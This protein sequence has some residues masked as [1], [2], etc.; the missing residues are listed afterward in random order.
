M[1]GVG[2]ALRLWRAEIGPLSRLAAAVAV[3][4]AGVV[5]TLDLV[6]WSAPAPGAE[7]RIRELADEPRAVDG[8]LWSA[9]AVTRWALGAL[10]YA[11]VILL[12][13]RILG[14]SRRPAPTLGR[15]VAALAG[16]L[17]ATAAFRIGLSLPAAALLAATL[18]AGTSYLVAINLVHAAG[19]VVTAP[20]LAATAWV[21]LP[22][23]RPPL[24]GG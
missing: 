17:A 16:A 1:S 19:K 18:D 21:A 23:L 4:V 5:L 10:V 11:V 13:A 15:R 2:E 3:P 8:P 9:L 24:S 7:V 14:P 6:A 12:G 22:R 20:L